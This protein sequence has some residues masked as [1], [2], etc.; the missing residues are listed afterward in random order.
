MYRVISPTC[1]ALIVLPLTILGSSV[2]AQAQQASPL[3]R[4]EALGLDTADVGRV[5]AYFEPAD[6][7]RAVELATLSDDAAHFFDRELGI[8]FD[9]GVAALPPEHWF[10]PIYGIPYAVPWASIPDRLLFVPSSLDEGILVQGRSSML[11][12]RRVIDFIALHEYGHVATKEYFHPDS[13]RDDLPIS[14]FNE[15][16]PNVFAYAFIASTDPEWAVVAR[17]MWLNVV[18]SREPPVLSL[19]WGFMNGLPPDELVRTY[20]WYQN[21]LNLRAAELVEEHGLDFLR[22]AKDRLAWEEAGDWTTESLLA[23]L[24]QV[25][26]G[27][28]SWAEDLEKGEYLQRDD[29]SASHPGGP[30]IVT[31]IAHDHSYVAPDTIPAGFADFRLVNR[32]DEPHGA[33]IVRLG[34]DRTLREYLAAYSEANRIGGPRPDWATFHGGPLAPTG[35]EATVTV[36]LEPGRGKQV[37]RVEN[38]GVEPHHVLLFKLLPGKTMEDYH[39]WLETGMQGDAPAEGVDASGE[40]STGEEAYMEVDL[41]TGDYLLV[42]LVAGQNEVPH[43]AMGMIEHVRVDRRAMTSSSRGTLP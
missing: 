33:T 42:C 6:R 12:R 5:T 2:S 29:G 13:E 17:E 18:K 3:E 30:P 16:L 28:L 15:L 38:L 39:A 36:D 21:L 31:I 8:S 7:D 11:E 34:D 4:V 27:F 23:S 19:D 20:A 32:G 1:L 9:L 41:S 35:G 37:I 43:V 40:L 10:E 25:F 26:P 22:V 24:G 14:W